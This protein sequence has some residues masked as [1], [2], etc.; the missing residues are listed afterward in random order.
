MNNTSEENIIKQKYDAL[1]DKDEYWN[2]PDENIFLERLIALECSWKK[3]LFRT[4][5]E[6]KSNQE[7]REYLKS[8]WRD[9][10]EKI[11]SKEYLWKK[12]TIVDVI[13]NYSK[14]IKKAFKEKSVKQAL[15]ELWIKCRKIDG[16][17]LPPEWNQRILPWNNELWDAE[18]EKREM[19]FRRFQEKFNI[20]FGDVLTVEN[21]IFPWD[22]E[23]IVWENEN[24]AL[25][26]KSYI[27]VWIKKLNKTI[28]INDIAWESTFVC[29]AIVSEEDMKSKS[30]KKMKE[31]LWDA[32]NSVS[33]SEN[34][35]EKWKPQGQV[36]YPSQ[37]L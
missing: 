20:L 7:V 19:N 32:L 5:L 23:V 29:D 14:E 12:M 21:E 11:I 26:F 28:F 8:K 34:Q 6:T 10:W 16:M 36:N 18:K 1:F 37:N 30:K 2:A 3:R 35:K 27:A 22:L 9:E 13:N 15:E 25:R 24:D 17:I 33:Y 4:L 31:Y